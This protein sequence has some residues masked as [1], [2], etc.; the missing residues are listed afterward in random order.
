M[1]EFPDV[2]GKTT[3]VLSQGIGMC[4]MAEKH[5]NQLGPAGKAFRAA[6]C[7]VF[8][9]QMRKSSSREMMKKL[10]KQAETFY[11]DCALFGGW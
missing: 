7:L 5:R 11:H 8:G 10:T 6:I 3:T 9:Y 1:F 2:A 4:H